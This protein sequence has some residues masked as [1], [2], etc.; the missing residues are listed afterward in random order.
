MNTPSSG[1]KHS[2]TAETL[3]P[4]PLDKPQSHTPMA[5]NSITLQPGQS[6]QKTPDDIRFPVKSMIG[7]TIGSA[8]IAGGIGYCFAVG[9]NPFEK[10]ETDQSANS[11]PT[12]AS[13]ATP[14][15]GP[16]YEN[17]PTEVQTSDQLRQI[18][19]AYNIE[20][21]PSDFL[22]ASGK[23][24]FFDAIKFTPD[25]G[26]DEK[27]VEPLSFKWIPMDSSKFTNPQGEDIIIATQ[28]KNAKYADALR[29]IGVLPQA[30]YTPEKTPLITYHYYRCVGPESAGI[31]SIVIE[32][33][34][35]RRHRNLSLYR[36]KL[37]VCKPDQ[38]P[39]Q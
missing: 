10:K 39:K 27:P 31:A 6:S 4:P 13:A 36:L 22:V 3:L 21:K 25:L 20:A 38:T 30:K 15:A 28:L 11:A 17:L 1:R 35:S 14:D 24:N 16:N 2:E 34:S 9:Y 23:N 5:L 26:P 8:L 18:I 32:D 29:N 7:A 12:S 37:P 33:R 19:E